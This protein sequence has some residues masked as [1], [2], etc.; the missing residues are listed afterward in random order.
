MKIRD[1]KEVQ[2]VKGSE[3]MM[4]STMW[5]NPSYNEMLQLLNQ[6]HE[7]RGLIDNNNADLYVWPAHRALHATARS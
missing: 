5:K 2:V 7:L 3:A 4:G 1:L 6:H